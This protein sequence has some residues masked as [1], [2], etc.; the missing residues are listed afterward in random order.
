MQETLRRIESKI[1]SIYGSVVGIGGV[2]SAKVNKNLPLKEQIKAAVDDE[3]YIMKKR[4]A[5]YYN[6]S[7][8]EARDLI[9]Q[10]VRELMES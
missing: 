5:T 7:W 9:N 4:I 3:L 10:S 6:L 8:E 2:E 1:D